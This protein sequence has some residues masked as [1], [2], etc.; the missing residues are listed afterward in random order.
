MYTY[1]LFI[2]LIVLT[3]LLIIMFAGYL[4]NH[5]VRCERRIQCQHP[6][7]DLEANIPTC[8]QP[9]PNV[10][11]QDRNDQR[12]S[13]LTTA[14]PSI[15][16]LPEIRTGSGHAEDWLDRRDSQIMDGDLGLKM[17]QVSDVKDEGDLE[18]RWKSGKGDSGYEEKGG[19]KT[20]QEGRDDN[21]TPRKEC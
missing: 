5:H 7:H 17:Y 11:Q 13:H 2:A 20:G 4:L 10:S 3:C 15:E 6:H 16:L 18:W 1:N 9:H 12:L 19:P 14:A 8:N 21:D